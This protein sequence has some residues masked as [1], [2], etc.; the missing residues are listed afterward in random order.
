MRVC[1]ALI[2]LTV[3]GPAGMANAYRLVDGRI[4][5]QGFQMFELSRVPPD[6]NIAPTQHSHAS[7]VVPLVFQAFEAV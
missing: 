3:C 1:I 7:R 6:L 2:R 5:H 4:L